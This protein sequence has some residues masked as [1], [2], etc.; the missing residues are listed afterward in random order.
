MMLCM[1]LVSLTRSSSK[2]YSLG[3]TQLG[4][5]FAKLFLDKTIPLSSG[6]FG[7]V[8]AY[9]LNEHEHMKFTLSV[10]QNTN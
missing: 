9:S 6:S 4:V 1:G 8:I 2:L 5:T 3:L 10:R 7:V